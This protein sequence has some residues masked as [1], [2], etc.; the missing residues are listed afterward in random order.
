VSNDEPVDGRCNATTRD[1]GYCAKDPV[2]GRDRCKSHGGQTPTKAE[3]PRQGAP[4]GNT[5]R[6][7]HGAYSDPANL[8]DNLDDGPKEFVD[9]LTE[10]YLG[11][12]PFDADDPRAD[13]LRMTSV[14]M[15][16][17]WAARGR[18]EA[19]SMEVNLTIGVGEG[20]IPVEQRDSHH[21][22]GEAARLNQT[23]RKNLK[24]LG[25]LDDPESQKADAMQVMS[26]E[27]YTIQIE[28]GDG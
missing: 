21:L 2:R 6:L 12:A 4:E 3:N 26:S 10:Q 28:P 18:V 27:D 7:E 1:G 5:N 9:R 22:L 13:R 14:I 24:D 19:E 16:Q 8:Y 25:L 15:Y 20:G 17:E 23:A 11:I